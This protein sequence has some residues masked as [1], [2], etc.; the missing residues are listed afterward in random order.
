MDTGDANQIKGVRDNNT[1]CD[2]YREDNEN[3]D[4]KL[5]EY[6]ED[7]KDDDNMSLDE[8]SPEET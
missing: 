2:F 5:T 4:T 6:H 7:T 1:T 8:E 3:W